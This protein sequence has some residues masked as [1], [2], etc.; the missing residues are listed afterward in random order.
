MMRHINR[1]QLFMLLF[2]L[3]LAITSYFI[4][5]Q[6]KMMGKAEYLQS[7]PPVQPQPLAAAGKVAFLMQEPLSTSRF[8]LD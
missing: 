5:V 3:V 4:P 2:A 6:E 7:S 8:L 1:K